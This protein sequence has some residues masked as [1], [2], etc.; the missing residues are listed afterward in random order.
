MPGTPR[1]SWFAERSGGGRIR[2]SSEC[3]VCQECGRLGGPLGAISRFEMGRILERLKRGSGGTDALM[4]WLAAQRWRDEEPLGGASVYRH[5]RG[6]GVCRVQDTGEFVLGS[7]LIAMEASPRFTHY[8]FCRHGLALHRGTRAP[9]RGLACD[10]P[11]A[12]SN[13]PTTIAFLRPGYGGGSR[14]A[15]RHCSNSSCERAGSHWSSS[16][17]P[18]S[19]PPPLSPPPLTPTDACAESPVEGSRT[20]A[21]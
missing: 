11:T 19:P 5:L 9:T 7:P 18:P 6:P 21:V 12:D 10:D 17:P 15:S 16:V 20:V 1:R 14:P 13:A 3:L 8:V 4:I 2:L